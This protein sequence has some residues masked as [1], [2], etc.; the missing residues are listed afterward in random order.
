MSYCNF[1]YVPG[2]GDIT[3]VSEVVS[4][5]ETDSVLKKLEDHTE[6]SFMTDNRT[7]ETLAQNI[8]KVKK[9]S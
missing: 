2:K 7:I 9:K 6:S 1:C 8:N 3:E 4:K 5:M